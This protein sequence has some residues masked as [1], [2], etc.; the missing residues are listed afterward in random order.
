MGCT[1]CTASAEGAPDDRVFDGR[2]NV[3][4]RARRVAAL[5]LL[6]CLGLN[7]FAFGNPLK[8]GVWALDGKEAAAEKWMPTAQHLSEH[9]PNQSFTVVPLHLDELI[10]KV[11]RNQLDFLIVDPVLYVQLEPGN[12][13]EI[14]AT[15]QCLYKGTRYTRSGG[16]LFTLKGSRFK[17]PQDLKGEVIATVN[18]R[19]LEDW[20]SVARGFQ[21]VGFDLR[22]DLGPVQSLG[23]AEAVVTAVLEGKA[24][25]G[26]VRAGT[27][28]H[29]AADHRLDLKSI[30]IL[31]FPAAKAAPV[32]TR[33]PVKI[34]TRSYPNWCFVACSRVPEDLA[35]DVAALLLTMVRDAPEILDRP[36]FAGWSSPRSDMIIHECLRVLR[37]PPYE[38]YGEISIVAVIR[39]YMYWFLLAG[40]LMIMMTLITLY[41]AALNHALS[42]EIQERKRIEVAL[43]ESIARFEN[44]ASCSADWIW[45]TDESGSYTYS[46]SIVEKMLG[47][48]KD[49]IIGRRHSDLFARVEKER[50]A[51]LGHTTI[52]NGGRVF[53]EQYRLLTKDGRVVIHESTAEP[54][55]DAQGQ[56]VGYRGVNRDI[57]DRVRFVSLRV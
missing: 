56:L 40:I 22:T 49:E 51:A 39:K 20:L 37:L 43:R 13:I 11:R 53:R 55:R 29:M 17:R 47:Y 7:R 36:N 52:G 9:V 3:C 19:S 6:L 48:K 32:A 45:E 50:L 25:A 46:S 10:D 23:S 44:V 16:A 24:V 15:L 38:R 1:C 33:I 28:E 30:S 54:I 12:D 42:A 34:S 41:V 14:L 26:A 27:L 4:F 2:T 8:I 31:S 18:M 21:D 57:T 35:K 5:V